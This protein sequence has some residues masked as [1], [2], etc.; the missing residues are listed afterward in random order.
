ME[1]KEVKEVY[2]DNLI[3]LCHI[4]DGYDEFNK[5]LRNLMADADNILN[6]DYLYRISKDKFIHSAKNVNQFYKK[7]RC[8]LDIG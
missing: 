1:N 5:N 4:L 8:V 3:A 6:I 2:I 7:N